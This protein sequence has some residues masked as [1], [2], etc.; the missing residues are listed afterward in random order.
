MN[1]SKTAMIWGANGGIGRGLVQH[2]V[3][4]DW[5]VAAINRQPEKTSD[6]TPHSFAADVTNDLAVQS[7]IID[8][9]YALGEIA[10]WVYRK[11]YYAQI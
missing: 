7:A 3:A 6:L 4:H 8:T 11:L 10:L 5:T 1:S 2:L 9:H